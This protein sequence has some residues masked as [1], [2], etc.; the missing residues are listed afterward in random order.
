MYGS[1]ELR[2][3]AFVKIAH[4]LGLPLDT[5][6]AILDAPSPQWREIVREQIVEL[7]EVIA[8]ARAA[9]S[10]LT[11]ALNCPADHPARECLTMIAALDRLVE[12]STVDQLAAEHRCQQV[13]HPSVS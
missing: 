12:G 6:A 8:R 3:L 2:R 10:F 11:H 7:G 5:A 9:Q 4:R 13:A 1:K